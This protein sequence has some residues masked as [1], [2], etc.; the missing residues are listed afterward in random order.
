MIQVKRKTDKNDRP[1]TPQEEILEL[2]SELAEKDLL[3]SD[4]QDQVEFVQL[5]VDEIILGGML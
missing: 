1:K 3:I 5:A 2:K 4:L